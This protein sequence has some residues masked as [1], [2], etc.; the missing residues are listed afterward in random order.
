MHN[1]DS[2]YIPPNASA[3]DFMYYSTPVPW[4]C[5]ASFVVF[6]YIFWVYVNKCEI[7]SLS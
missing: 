5:Q 7:A 6:E 3:Q 4:D 2:C 1:Q